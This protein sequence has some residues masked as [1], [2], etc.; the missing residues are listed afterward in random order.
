VVDEVADEA[1]RDVPVVEG[2]RRRLGKVSL[3]VRADERAPTRSQ[4]RG[5][6]SAAHGSDARRRREGGERGSLG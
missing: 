1:D 2:R 3:M 6:N 5:S 4:R